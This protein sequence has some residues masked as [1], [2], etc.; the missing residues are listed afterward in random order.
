MRCTYRPKTS[1]ATARGLRR[2]P[3]QPAASL[4]RQGAYTCNASFGVSYNF[5]QMRPVIETVKHA[6]RYLGACCS[7]SRHLF[8]TSSVC[9][10]PQCLLG[11]N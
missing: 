7:K 5:S 3:P 8:V 2:S 11:A 4:R 1:R 6:Y 10:P 9:H